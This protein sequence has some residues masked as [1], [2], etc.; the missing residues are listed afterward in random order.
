MWLPATLSLLSL[1]AQDVP[2]RSDVPFPASENKKGLQVQMVDDALSLGIGHATLNVLL[3]GV[4]LSAGGAGE[5]G[6]PWTHG[7]TVIRVS[8]A[9]LAPLD[10]DIKALSDAGCAVYLILLGNVT[11]DAA[12]NALL[13]DPDRDEAPRNGYAGFNAHL[14]AGKAHLAALIDFLAARYSG[15]RFGDDHGHVHGWIVGNEVNSHGHWHSVGPLE[16]GELTRRYEA[17]VRTVH[18]AATA[19][20]KNARTYISLDHFWGRAFQPEKPKQYVGGRAFIGAFAKHAKASGDFPWHIAHHPYPENLFDPAFWED[21]T[22]TDDLGTPRV[23]FKNL[24]VLGRALAAEELHFEGESRRVILSEQGFHRPGSEAGETL[25]A[26]AY[27]AAWKLVQEMPFID[28]FVLHRHVDH[29]R[30]GGL[31]LGLWTHKEGSIATP[32]RK[33][34]MH[35]VFEAAGTDRESEAFAFA[36][37]VIGETNWRDF[38]APYR[39][40][41]QA[42]RAP[43]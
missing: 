20:Y 6:I 7:E 43:R 18:L 11:G 31:R 16:V 22:A 34:L 30:E 26:A 12:R 10:R 15:G 2:A 3:N 24:R 21:T 36:L 17:A 25:Q 40:T 4:L 42:Q 28:A 32:D 35:R 23:T 14:P 19:R 33:V 8:G 29:S 41:A 9:Y 13:L 27:A 1:F 37:G 38:L 39:F 5:T